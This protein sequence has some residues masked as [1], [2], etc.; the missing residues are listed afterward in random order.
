MMVTCSKMSGWVVNDGNV[1]S[2]MSGWVV[3]D[4]NV[5]KKMEMYTILGTCYLY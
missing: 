2:K 3:N 1:C 4:G 5:F